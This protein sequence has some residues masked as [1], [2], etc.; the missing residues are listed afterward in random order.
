MSQTDS[1][2]HLYLRHFPPFKRLQINREQ[3]C[4]KKWCYKMTYSGVALRIEVELI[5]VQWRY[6]MR[7]CNFFI[8][9][10]IFLQWFMKFSL[11]HF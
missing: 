11:K 4:L 9:H 7:G 1:S 10:E 6:S 5:D 8:R 3:Y 2:H